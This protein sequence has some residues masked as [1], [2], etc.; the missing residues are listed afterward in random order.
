MKIYGAGSLD[1]IR[2]CLALGVSGILT[3]PQGFDQYYGGNMTLAE[4][5]RAICSLTDLPVYIQIHGETPDR[6]VERAYELHRISPKQVGF[7]IIADEKGFLSIRRLSNAGIRCIATTLFSLPQ[8]A[9]AASAGAAG[10]C[11]F[12]SRAAEI[13]MDPCDVIRSIRSG[14]DRLANPPEII[15]VSTKSVADVELA[16]RAGA[17]AVGMRYPLLKAMAEHP[18]SRKAEL[19]FAKNWANVKGEDI[20]YLKD[21]MRLEGIAE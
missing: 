15:A 12:I 19:L 11:P 10:I 6:I 5:T 2:A 13:G 18:L 8:A 4:I 21:A 14:Y 3:N 17:D 1:D 20:S 16:L 9:V 7:K